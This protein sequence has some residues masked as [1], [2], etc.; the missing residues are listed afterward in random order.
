MIKRFINCCILDTVCNLDCEYC[1]VG[2]EGQHVRESTKNSH[3]VEE[4]RQALSFQRLGGCCHMNIFATGETLLADNIIELVE[5]F[6]NEGHIVSIVTNAL[7]TKKIDELC[8]LSSD[9]KRRLFIKVSFHFLELKKKKL[10]TQFWKNVNKIKEA[11]IS[12]TVELTVN[13]ASV[14]YI[15]EIQRECMDHLGAYCHVIEARIQDGKD[16][17]RLT[18]MDVSAHQM[19]WKVFKSPLFEFQQTIWGQPRK[20]F[21]Y[22]GDWICSIDLK[23]GNVAPC[24][25]GGHVLDNIYTDIGRPI[26]FCA[27][28]HQ[29]PWGHCYAAYVLLTHGAIPDFVT[30][31]YAEE[32][33][34]LCKDGT[35]WLQPE[36]RKAFS[37]RLQEQNEQYSELRRQM[38]DFLMGC[39]YDN[40]DNSNKEE[41]I[42]NLKSFMSSHGFRNVAIYGAGKVGIKLYELLEQCQIKVDCFMDRQFKELAT[43]APCIASESLLD[44]VDLIIVSVYYQYTGIKKMLRGNGNWMPILN[45]ANIE[46]LG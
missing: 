1:Y 43:P 19:A 21:C 12:F 24:N 8:G 18:T 38:T 42:Y 40:Y 17:P 29:C 16:W 35:T 36:I 10:F 14:S 2:Q 4:I 34:R 6:I 30:P 39:I 31:T 13:D 9:I 28:G 37:E 11:G 33:D 5:A 41:L 45:L 23:S 3:S 46:D 15:N 26:N 44:G 22:A 25:G 32:R 7:I 27:I 20:E